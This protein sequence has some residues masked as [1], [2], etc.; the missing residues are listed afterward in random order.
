MKVVLAE[1]KSY[2]QAMAH[3][4]QPLEP[5][6][7]METTPR[8]RETP[9]AYTEGEMFLGPMPVPASDAAKAV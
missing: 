6:L 4:E 7:H 3:V 5:P 2:I 8:M 9:S 1:T